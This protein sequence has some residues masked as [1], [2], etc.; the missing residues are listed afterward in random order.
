M[1]GMV[2][3]QYTFP[4]PPVPA[5]APDL[6]R[7]SQIPE[8][9]R[10]FQTFATPPTLLEVL[11]DVCNSCEPEGFIGFV[12]AIVAILATM[13]GQPQAAASGFVPDGRMLSDE[14]TCGKSQGG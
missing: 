2:F 9:W 8:S 3:Y 1:P 7:E 4:P 10:E 11:L 12:L 5:K 6:S 14:C 13:K